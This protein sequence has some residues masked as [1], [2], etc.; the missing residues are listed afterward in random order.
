M[1]LVLAHCLNHSVGLEIIEGSWQATQR[2]SAL[3][4][5]EPKSLTRRVSREPQRGHSMAG[6]ARRRLMPEM[7]TARSAGAAMP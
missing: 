5:V 1:E 4:D 7:S 2:Y 3:H 6:A